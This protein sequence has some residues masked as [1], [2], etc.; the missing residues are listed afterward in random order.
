VSV[1]CRRLGPGTGNATADD[2]A[3]GEPDSNPLS[4]KTG[5][6]AQ[7]YPQLF[8]NPTTAASQIAEREKAAKAKA[9]AKKPK[10][11]AK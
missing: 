6:G 5:Q 3:Q 11:G 4:P 8:T 10:A 2:L 1:S 7:F 9:K